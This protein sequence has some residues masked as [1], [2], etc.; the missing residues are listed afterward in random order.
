MR[1]WVYRI[2]TNTALRRAERERRILLVSEPADQPTVDPDRF[3]GADQVFPGHWQDPPA[4]WTDPVRLA[5]SAELR[6]VLKRAIEGLPPAQRAVI[7]L[8]DVDG[9]GSN[10]TCTLLEISAANQR[11]LLHRARAAVRAELERYLGE[12]GSEV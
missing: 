6:A 10:E 2:L 1:H 3:R 7:T 12:A 5:E 9:I 4:P 11:V 8:R